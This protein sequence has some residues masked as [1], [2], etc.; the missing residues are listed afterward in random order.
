MCKVLLPNFYL[1]GAMKAGTTTIAR[2]LSKHPDVYMSPVKEPNY[3]C[4]DLY[5]YGLGS[6]GPDGIKALRYIESGRLLHNAFFQERW[7]YEALFN[8]AS[9]EPIIAE[10]STNYLYSTDAAQNIYNEVPKARVLIILRNPVKRAYSEFLMN[11][12]IGTARPPFSRWLD[13]EK[14]QVEA[15]IVPVKHRYVSAGMYSSQVARFLELFGPD[16]TKIILFDDLKADLDDTVDQICRFLTIQMGCH[17]D[18]IENPAK[19][20]RHAITNYWAERFGLKNAISII[21]PNRIKDYFKEWYYSAAADNLEIE[22]MDLDRL[23]GEFAADVAK[24]SKMLNVDL[25]NRWH[26]Y[27]EN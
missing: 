2:I 20:P 13:F 8:S 15:G 26:I 27:E 10:C 1:V 22:P 24:L 18:G 19:L 7:Q 25:N 23:I 5:K 3:F 6:R 21:V 16:Q 14:R 4:T 9:N 12:S 11:C 17:V